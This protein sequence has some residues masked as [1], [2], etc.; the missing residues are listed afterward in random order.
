MQPFSIPTAKKEELSKL[1][2]S[3]SAN[4]YVSGAYVDKVKPWID[5]SQISNDDAFKAIQEINTLSKF[6]NI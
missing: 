6:T 3:I 5:V 2:G 1:L 4:D